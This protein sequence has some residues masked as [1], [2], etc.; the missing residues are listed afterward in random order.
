VGAEYALAGPEALSFGQVAEKIAA[1]TGREIRFV[2]PPRE[3]WIATLE[4]GGVPSDYAQLL[5]MLADNIRAHATAASTPDVERVT[6]RP[7]RSFDDYAA[8]PSV[9]AAWTAPS[10]VSAAS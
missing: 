2:D 4:S 6:G 5:G 8:Q 9:V 1:A 7:P 3:E 10:A